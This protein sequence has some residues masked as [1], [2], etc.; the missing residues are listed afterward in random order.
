MGRGSFP[1]FHPLSQQWNNPRVKATTRR[2]EEEQTHDLALVQPRPSSISAFIFLVS[3]Y[4]SRQ[5]VLSLAIS[6][7]HRQCTVSVLVLAEL[8]RGAY[9]QTNVCPGRD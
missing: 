6:S 8:A 9:R 3:A 2:R 5:S 1:S 4:E 7:S